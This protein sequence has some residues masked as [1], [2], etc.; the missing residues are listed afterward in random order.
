MGIA[1]KNIGGRVLRPYS[2]VDAYQVSSGPGNN[3]GLSHFGP[4]ASS[5]FITCAPWGF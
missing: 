2:P 5:I 4:L 3:L 1:R